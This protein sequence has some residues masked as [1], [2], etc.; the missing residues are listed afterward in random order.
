MAFY[1]KRKKGDKL[2]AIWM[3]TYGDLAML[4]VT[5]FVL[6]VSYM[7]ME[8]GRLIEISRSFRGAVGLQ[9]GGV[10]AEL[11]ESL[12]LYSPDQASKGR[13]AVR[14]EVRRTVENLIA[15]FGGAGV[16]GYVEVKGTEDG[17]EFVLKD[18]LL[19]DSGKADVKPAAH[20][21]LDIIANTIRK[22][23]V[24]A[25]VGGHTDDRPIRTAVFPSN[26]ELSAMR[27][28]EVM[29]YMEKR[30]RISPGKLQA[31]GYGEYRPLAS[32][33]TEEGRAKN[34]RVE[35]KLTALN[36]DGNAGEEKTKE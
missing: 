23:D 13:V 35:I 9:Q 6:I 31:R 26:W 21:A 28:T 15:Q 8:Q 11:G 7:Q 17:V 30:F 34:R 16:E 36:K 27:A 4:L 19:F 22:S 32:N 29:L 24:L 14:E 5:F 10:S 12:K 20:D 3:T 1:R 2:E 18:D 33:D 25:V